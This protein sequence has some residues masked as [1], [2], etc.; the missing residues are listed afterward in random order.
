M[1]AWLSAPQNIPRTT[2]HSTMVPTKENNYAGQNYLGY[3]NDKMDTILNDLEV[4]CEAEENLQL[5]HDLQNLYAEDL[6]ALPLYFR[7][8]V[9]VLPN[10]LKGVD[11]TGHQYPS[12]FWIE[13]W[14]MK[15]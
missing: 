6:P 9:H 5:W 15:P 3:K 8:E 11:P 10:W 4:K 12:T 2:L 13:N 1:Y 7:S 14:S